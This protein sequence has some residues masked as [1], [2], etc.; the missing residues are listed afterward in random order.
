QPQVTIEK[1]EIIQPAKEKEA[2]VAE[3]KIEA[4]EEAAPASTSKWYVGGSA[5]NLNYGASNVRSNYGLGV[6]VGT[7]M[8]DN[9]AIEAEYNYS[10]QYIHDLWQ[11]QVYHTLNQTDFTGAV[12]YYFMAGKLKPYAGGE[13]S[14]ITRVYTDRIYGYPY[15]SYGWGPTTETTHAVNMGIL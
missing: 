1:V 2:P 12:K 5:G 7:L 14:Y 10:N 9:L 3:S 15:G 4:K 13:L 11:Q 8:N 6:A